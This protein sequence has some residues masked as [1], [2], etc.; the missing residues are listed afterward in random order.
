MD[1]TTSTESVPDPTQCPKCES[2]FIQFSYFS[3]FNSSDGMQCAEVWKCESCG[4]HWE[5]DVIPLPE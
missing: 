1:E 3:S 2:T 5:H 4:H